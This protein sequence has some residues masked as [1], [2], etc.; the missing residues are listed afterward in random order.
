MVNNPRG[1]FAD[2][3]YARIANQIE[4]MTPADMVGSLKVDQIYA[5]AQHESTWVTG[6]NAGVRIHNHPGG[7]GPKYLEAPFF[8]NY[9]EWMQT[10]AHSVLHEGLGEGMAK[11]VE[12]IDRRMRPLVPRLHGYLSL[13]GHPTVKLGARTVYDRP[14]RIHRLSEAELKT[15]ARTHRSGRRRR[16]R[17]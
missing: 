12:G 9:A 6:P 8:A 5:R 7:G 2:E 17:H 15:I 11:V 3:G 13:S 4:G 1:K 10:L 14:P 16:G